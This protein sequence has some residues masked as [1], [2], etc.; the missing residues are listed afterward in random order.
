MPVFYTS[1]ID[2]KQAILGEEESRHIIKVMRMAGGDALEIV[3]GRGNLYTGVLSVPDP[4]SCHVSI[5][6]VTT[7]YLR[8]DYHLHIAIAPPKSTERFEWFLEKATEI[9]VDEISPIIC[10]RSERSR[11]RHE[12]SDKIL[13]AAMKQCGRA[14]LPRLN[15][16]VSW[17][18]FLDRSAADIKLIAHCHTSKDQR[19]DLEG[20][21]DMSWIIMIGPEGD[22]TP[23]EIKEARLKTYREINLGEATYRTETAGI[24]ACH[25][26]SLLYQNKT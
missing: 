9:G 20:H 8:R 14:L 26:I 4:K 2:N 13:I 17:K 23:E 24:I 1:Q 25:T 12:R 19:I 3:D 18:D 5:K 11:L 15:R 10:T 16:E 6:E 7:G 21:K 22:F